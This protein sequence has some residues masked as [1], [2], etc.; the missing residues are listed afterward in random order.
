MV[1]WQLAH[2]P[3]PKNIMIGIDADKR[4]AGFHCETVDVNTGEQVFHFETPDADPEELTYNFETPELKEL[5][6]NEPPLVRRV[7][8]I[9]KQARRSHAEYLATGEMND[10]IISDVIRLAQLEPIFRAGYVD[11]NIGSVDERDIED[12]W[13][14]FVTLNRFIEESLSFNF[15]ADSVCELNPVFK[16][17]A[18]V[19]GADADLIVDRTLI[20][21]KTTKDPAVQREHL[22]QLIGYY[23]LATSGRDYAIDTLALYYSR[24]GELYALSVD[25][26]I[27]RDTFPSFVNWFEKR[28]EEEKLRLR[29]KARRN[30]DHQ[31]S[32]KIVSEHANKLT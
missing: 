15:K 24:F 25:D 26:V 13:N 9:A 31:P 12:Q 2:V 22:N 21:I 30:K 18:L 4:K 1:L 27:N 10:R 7:R 6:A 17:S 3:F 14:L 19:G 16:A 23:V 11:K 5:V 29:E 20:D 28:A 8:K 32:E